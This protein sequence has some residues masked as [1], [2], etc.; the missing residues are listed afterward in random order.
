MIG[1]S[2]WRIRIRTYVL[3]ESSG[4]FGR[5]MLAKLGLVL[6]SECHNLQYKSVAVHLSDLSGNWAK[7]RT[8]CGTNTQQNVA[9]SLPTGQTNVLGLLSD[10]S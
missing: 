1:I 9:E 6:Q 8:K 5:S 7:F 4:Q 10:S 3:F 2:F